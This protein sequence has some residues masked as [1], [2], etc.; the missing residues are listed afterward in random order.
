MQC[1]YIR[2]LVTYDISYGIRAV[3]IWYIHLLSMANPNNILYTK[4]HSSENYWSEV[5]D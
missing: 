3:N 5:E 4:Y 1:N 2:N